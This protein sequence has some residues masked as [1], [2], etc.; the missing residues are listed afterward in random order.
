M[1]EVRSFQPVFNECCKLLILGSCPSTASLACGENYAHPR[2]R[3]W[4]VMASLLGEEYPQIYEDKKAMLLRHGIALWDVV[5][6]CSR[7]G[8]LDSA[9]RDA[10]VNDIPGLL[11]QCPK[12]KT[13]A[14]NGSTAYTLFLRHIGKIPGIDLLLLPST[15]PIPRRGLITQDD[16]LSA[17]REKLLPVL[18]D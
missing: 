4:P 2:N 7:Q 13:I 12:I 18:K 1:N 9:I 5:R 3:F 17:W 6:S 10:E 14:I 15:S 11:E 8:S 16:I